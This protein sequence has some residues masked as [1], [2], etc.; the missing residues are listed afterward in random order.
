MAEHQVELKKEFRQKKMA[1]YQKLPETLCVM[2]AIVVVGIFVYLFSTEK[3]GAIHSILLNFASLVITCAISIY[4]GKHFT[5]QEAYKRME[6]EATKA[7]RRIMRIKDAT[8]RLQENCRRMITEVTHDF[9]GNEKK[10]LNEY[11]NGIHNQLADILGNVDSSID[12]WGDMLPDKVRSI[13]EAENESLKII[14][15]KQEQFEELFNEYKNKLETAGKEQREGLERELDKKA[16]NL[17]REL[18]TEITQKRLEYPF[19]GMLSSGATIT[20]PATSGSGL[21]FTSEGSGLASGL[22]SSFLDP[23][24]VSLFYHDTT[25]NDATDDDVNDDNDDNDK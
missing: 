6:G 14:L 24:K 7:L 12:D 9:S 13:K 8:I 19:S 21:T 20:V 4:L 16:S 22:Y 23:K 2:G 10:L 25:E 3:L 5:A 17:K 1:L 15:K 18:E 11:F